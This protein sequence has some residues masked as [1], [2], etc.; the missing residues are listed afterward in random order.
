L[1][2]FPAV[3]FTGIRQIN[4]SSIYFESSP[5]HH[6][7]LYNRW[8][9]SV[10]TAVDEIASLSR[11]TCRQMSGECQKPTWQFSGNV[12]VD[13]IFPPCNFN[14]ARL[15]FG[16]DAPLPFFSS[17]DP[18]NPTSSFLSRVVQLLGAANLRA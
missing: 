15:N 4:R 11:T 14:F 17:A 10:A 6:A 13:Q 9:G 3:K 5:A 16:C 2:L 18:A 8:L 7:P 12:F 1:N